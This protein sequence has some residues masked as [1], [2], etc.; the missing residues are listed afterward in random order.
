MMMMKSISPI[1]S[2]L[3]HLPGLG[4]KTLISGV[5]RSRQNCRQSVP[6]NEGDALEGPGNRA[7]LLA[8]C[9]LLPPVAGNSPLAELINK[10]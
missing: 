5:S 10:I 9:C 2:Y 4:Q 7:G 3:A 6:L 1:E 8:C